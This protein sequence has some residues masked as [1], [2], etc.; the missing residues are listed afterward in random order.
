MRIVSWNCGGGFRKKAASILVL[1]PDLLIVQEITESDAGQVE[2]RAAH[3]VGLPGRKGVA[4]FGFADQPCVVADVR[5][6]DLRWFLPVH[7]NGLFILASWAHVVTP[8]RRYV[9]VMHEALD[10]YQSFLRAQPSII[11]GDLNSNT[12]FD[13]KHRGKSHT[14]LV[15]RLDVMGMSSAYH[16][17]SGEAHGQE[18]TPTFFLYRHR[19]KPYHFDYVFGSN[20]LLDDA[21]LWI[22]AVDDWI[23]LSD[24][25]PLILDLPDRTESR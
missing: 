24:H 23:S 25:L 9:R 19:D 18:T 12:V 16:R 22:S 2:A 21:R 7:W 4:V 10:H 6:T 8:T 11:I 15:A 1:E 14:D 13:H 3:W 5:P 20:D 17:A